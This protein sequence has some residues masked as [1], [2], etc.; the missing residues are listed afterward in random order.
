MV[1][2]DFLSGDG[3]Q[4]TAQVTPVAANS[5]AATIVEQDVEAPEVFAVTDAAL[6]DG[7]P[8]LGGVWVAHPDVVEPE[9][10]LIRNTQNGQ[11]LVGALFRREREQP[12]PVV[13]VSSDAANGLQILAGAPTEL[14]IVALRRQ[15]INAAPEPEPTLVAAPVIE[16][17]VLPTAPAPA[18][19]AGTVV[20]VATTFEPELDDPS[21]RVTA[22]DEPDTGF[23]QDGLPPIDLASLEAAPAPEP[24]DLEP[25]AIAV[26]TT[27]AEA[28]AAAATLVLARAE[29]PTPVVEPLAEPAA[30][31]VAELVADPFVPTTLDVAP[32]IEATSLDQPVS[33]DPI[34]IAAAATLSEAQSAAALLTLPADDLV[35]PA[36]I[37]ATPLGA[38]EAVSLDPIAI[39]AENAIASA[40]ADAALEPQNASAQM[41]DRA[42]VQIG[43]F[44]TQANAD[45]AADAMRA[46]GIVP[47]IRTFERGEQTYYRVVVGPVTSLAERD[48]VLASVR[49][50]GYV[51]A[52]PVTN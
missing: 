20:A 24:A 5:G 44:S 43:V 29:V 4:A 33:L 32:I 25:L 28:E 36:V 51:D 45:A 15:D 23:A 12:G 13:Q 17:E 41:P 27:L 6:W 31:P 7:R 40:E 16:G 52:Y 39:A 47:G 34:A 22:L 49:A 19:E 3:T 37:E 50:E 8:S 14:E 38:P 9:R 21:M 48:S 18:D 11:E 35:Q 30:E 2:P 1:L 42:Y 26:A 46:A 10:V